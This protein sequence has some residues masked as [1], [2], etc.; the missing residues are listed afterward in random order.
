MNTTLSTPDIT[1][2]TFARLRDRKRVLW[3]FGGALFLLFGL[4]SLV[5][6]LFPGLYIFDPFDQGWLLIPE[7]LFLGPVIALLHHRIMNTGSDFSWSRE[8]LV[9]KCL[10]AWAYYYVLLILFKVGTFV[11]TTVIPSLLGTVLGPAV[12]ALF[13]VIVG[14]GFVLFLLV[15]VLLVLVYPALAGVAEEPL[16]T[17]YR[18]TRGKTRQIVSCLL[19]LAAPVLIPWV[20]ATVYGGD[21]L[22]PSRGP[23][24]QIVPIIARSL[25]LTLGAIVISTGLCIMYEALIE[26]AEQTELGENDQ[27]A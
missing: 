13:P 14:A 27:D 6:A 18:L 17:S 10:K 15:Y 21:M 20:A 3:P 1:Q 26:E 9:V 25:L 2:K 23:G 11:T 4:A 12:G 8:N 19:L 22:D 24:V 5:R 16:V 7:A